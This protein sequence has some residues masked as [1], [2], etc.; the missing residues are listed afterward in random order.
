M[1]LHFVVIFFGNFTHM[2]GHHICILQRGEPISYGNQW[3]HNAETGLGRDSSD[4]T[5]LHPAHS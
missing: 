2:Y 4:G 5:G 3:E 1:M